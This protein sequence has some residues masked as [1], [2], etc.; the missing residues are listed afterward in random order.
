VTDTSSSVWRTAYVRTRFESD[1]VELGPLIAV[2]RAAIA[3]RLSSLVEIGKPEHE[4]IEAARRV[5]T[6]LKARRGSIVGETLAL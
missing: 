3:E 5:P 1:A 4:A 6:S 2:A